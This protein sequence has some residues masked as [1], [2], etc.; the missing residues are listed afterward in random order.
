[1]LFFWLQLVFTFFFIPHFFK[2]LYQ[3]I[4]A[5]LLTAV[6][7]VSFLFFAQVS[8]APTVAWPAAFQAAPTGVTNGLY[9]EGLNWDLAA[10]SYG[11]CVLTVNLVSGGPSALSCQFANGANC[12]TLAE[13]AFCDLPAS[14]PS[15]TRYSVETVFTSCST[16]TSITSPST[17]VQYA[18]TITS[19]TVAGT[20]GIAVGGGTLLTITGTSMGTDKTKYGSFTL[21]DSGLYLSSMASSSWTSFS[22]T[23]FVVSAPSWWT[24]DGADYL[25]SS[26]N[27]QGSINWSGGSVAS[28]TSHVVNFAIMA[29]TG[30]GPASISHTGGAV[31]SITGQRFGFDKTY[32]RNIEM[33]TSDFSSRIYWLDASYPEWNTMNVTDTLITHFMPSGVTVTGSNVQIGVGWGPACKSNAYTGFYASTVT[34]T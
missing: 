7:V 12:Q 29:V 5:T 8:A 16:A 22:N 13:C 27:M 1:L 19:L 25:R 11:T 23:G 24:T 15:T 18:P 30:L 3:M 2:I 10:N 21:G 34:I 6:V 4:R 28:G 33:K 32:L 14:G 20:G 31:V 26:A 17:I 9:L